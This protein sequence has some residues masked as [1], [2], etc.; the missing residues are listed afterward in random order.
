M[1]A[2]FGPGTIAGQGHSI[3]FCAHHGPLMGTL[4]SATLACNGKVEVS[5]LIVAN[6][7][8]FKSSR[9]GRQAVAL[10]VQGGPSV[11]RNCTFQS[12][13]DTLCIEGEAVFINCTIIGCIDFIF[14]SGNALFQS[15]RI[16][17]N[18]PGFVCAPSTWKGRQGLVLES[19]SL[20][21]ACAL[22]A[23]SVKLARPWHPG[24]RPGRVPKVQFRSCNYGPHID[25][26]SPWAD[27][28][29]T[30]SV[31]RKAADSLFSIAD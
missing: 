25:L 12:F 27:M 5:D 21:S 11:F 9:D 17:S 15:C 10:L 23:G 2:A 19:C 30:F 4:A 26:S 8:D 1:K 22:P 7:F 29:D 3:S 18:G 6:D 31:T 28:K 13:H 14:G 16:L 24:G 20:E